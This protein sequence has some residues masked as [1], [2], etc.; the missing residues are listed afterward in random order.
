MS[1]VIFQVSCVPCH[2]SPTSTAT[3][4][5]PSPAISPLF[6]G[7]WF[8]KCEQENDLIQNHFF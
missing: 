3:A 2:L 8:S 1:Q 5:T 4:K 7:G 6:T